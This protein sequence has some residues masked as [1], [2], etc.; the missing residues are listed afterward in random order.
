MSLAS[1]NVADA[2]K[3]VDAVRTA[4]GKCAGFREEGGLWSY[5]DVRAVPGPVYGD[6]SVSVKLTQIVPIG[7]GETR[8]VPFAIVV[9]RKGGVVATFYSFSARRGESGVSVP[10]TILK[11]QMSKLDHL[12]AAG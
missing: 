2:G 3:V 7:D 12:P 11:A 4:A 8:Q 9:A 1:H 5:T 6:E 10:E